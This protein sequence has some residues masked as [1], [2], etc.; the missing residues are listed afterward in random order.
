MMVRLR[1]P[2]ENPPTPSSSEESHPFLTLVP[3]L[4][5]NQEGKLERMNRITCLCGRSLLLAL[6]GWDRKA[7]IQGSHGEF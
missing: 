1:T 2:L 3:V 7:S 6:D 4:G 5:L